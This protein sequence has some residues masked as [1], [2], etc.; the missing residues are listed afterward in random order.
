MNTYTYD[1]LHRLTEVVQTGQSGANWIKPKRVTQTFNALGQRTGIARFESTGT[2]NPVATTAFTYDTANRLNGIEHKQGT[3]NLNTYAYTYDPLSRLAKVDSTAEGLTSYSYDKWS[4][5]LGATNTGVANESYDYDDNGNRDTGHTVTTDNRTTESP[6]VTYEYDD[7][8]NMTLATDG[9]TFWW[10]YKWDHRNRLI[11]AKEGYSRTIRYEYDAFNRL[12]SRKVNFVEPGHSITGHSTYWVYDEGINPII[13]FNND[14]TPRQLYLW[15]DAV[16]DLLAAEEIPSNPS[17]GNILWPLADHL[18]TIRD[19]ADRNDSTGV[20]NVS[21]HRRYDAFGNRLSETNSAVDLIFGFTGKLFDET[22]GLQNNLNRWY[23]PNIG[24]W[25]SQD[26]IG[27][28]AGD[29]N[30]YRY[31][32]NAP[33]HYVDPLGLADWITEFFRG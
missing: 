7:E 32:G 13:E 2:S 1:K 28:N 33:T 30:L 10:R 19:I 5:L 29:A 15:S 27:F 12:Y 4:Q 6:G 31:V 18:G 22:V 3:T 24:K 25:I 20:T 9:Q 11:E 16:D 17:A 26:P 14:G 8:G 21:N 23:D